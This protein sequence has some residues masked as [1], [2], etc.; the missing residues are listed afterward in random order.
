MPDAPSCPGCAHC[1]C[2][3]PACV[4]TPEAV[5]GYLDAMDS[6]VSAWQ[7]L[8]ECVQGSECP[9]CDVCEDDRA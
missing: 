6:T 3:C 1:R 7:L 8:N 4:T 9:G 2:E 5:D